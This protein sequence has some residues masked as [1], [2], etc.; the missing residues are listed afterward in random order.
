[1][2]GNP[3]LLGKC[4]ITRNKDE[5]SWIQRIW[6]QEGSTAKVGAVL[7][8]KGLKKEGHHY[9]QLLIHQSADLPVKYP[10]TAVRSQISFGYLR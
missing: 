1:M 10:D 6:Q 2:L 8:L 9:L 5:E 3:N 7:T 4:K